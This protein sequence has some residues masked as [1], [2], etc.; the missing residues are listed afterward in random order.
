MCLMFEPVLI[1]TY[2]NVKEGS[3][4]RL[5]GYQVCIN[6]NILE[7]KVSQFQVV[8]HRVIRINRNILEC[9]GYTLLHGS[10]Q[11]SC[12]NRNILECKVRSPVNH[13]GCDTLVLIETYW[14]VKYA[15]TVA[16]DMVAIVLIETYWNVK[17]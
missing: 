9:K 16:L 13:R 7:C 8:K 1:E 17:A 6:R 12:I 4:T 11:R 2:W 5:L 15:S 14:N 3:A 10:H